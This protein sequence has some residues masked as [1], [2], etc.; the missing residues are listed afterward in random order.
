MLTQFGK[1]DT[2]AK[3]QSHAAR[4]QVTVE[5]AEIT[6]IKCAVFRALTQITDEN[7]ET[8][9]RETVSHEFRTS[10]S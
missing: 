5:N 8:F 9:R 2:A 3:S 1:E 7:N 10:Q 6:E 4:M